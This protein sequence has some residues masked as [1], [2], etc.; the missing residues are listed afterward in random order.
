[1]TVGI[2]RKSPFSSFKTPK[3]A[4]VTFSFPYF[5]IA[6]PASPAELK[7]GS[8]FPFP[9]AF[10]AVIVNSAIFIP[11]V[12]L[13]SLFIFHDQRVYRADS[14]TLRIYKYRVQIHLF[15]LI[16]VGISI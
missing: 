9:V 6:V 4:S 3:V 7:L 11:P 10:D 15:D 14:F 2:A 5:A 12:S 1:S 13:A 8:G 16:L